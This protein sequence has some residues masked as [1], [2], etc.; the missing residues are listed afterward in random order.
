MSAVSVVL[1][2]L[3]SM[4]C[5]AAAAEAHHQHYP[6]TAVLVFAVGVGVAWVGVVTL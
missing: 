4:I 6:I 3:A 2:L 1:C 5:G